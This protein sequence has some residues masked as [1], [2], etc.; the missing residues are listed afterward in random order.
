MPSNSNNKTR[1]VL[2]SLEEE[3]LNIHT[4]EFQQGYRD[5]Y[6]HESLKSEHPDYMAG[7][8]HGSKDR[9]RDRDC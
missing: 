7:Y 2:P 6:T 4:P 5:A 8:M 9:V 1:Q 3:A